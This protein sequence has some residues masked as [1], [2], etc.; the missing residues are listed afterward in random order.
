MEMV[1][2]FGNTRRS[3][4]SRNPTIQSVIYVHRFYLHAGVNKNWLFDLTLTY[5]LANTVFP[6][7]KRSESVSKHEQSRQDVNIVYQRPCIDQPI[8]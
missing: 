1:Y 8:Y 7:S 5:K 6:T 2:S 4:E 3:P